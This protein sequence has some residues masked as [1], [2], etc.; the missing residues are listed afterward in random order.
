[1]FFDANI[2]GIL[3]LIPL[4]ALGMAVHTCNPSYSGGEGRRISISRSAKAKLVR[5]YLK[6]KIKRA[7]GG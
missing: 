5:P 1:L 6:N 3:Y 2:N 7:G 4:L